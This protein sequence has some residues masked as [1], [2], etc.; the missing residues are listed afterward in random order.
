MTLYVDTCLAIFY[1]FLER[2][3]LLNKGGNNTIQPHWPVYINKANLNSL[4]HVKEKQ[5]FRM[6]VNHDGFK[7]F[8]KKGIEL[9]FTS[10]VHQESS[11]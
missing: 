5:H 6:L 3:F 2:E 11:K 9:I 10:I 7:G 8:F 1:S 4:I